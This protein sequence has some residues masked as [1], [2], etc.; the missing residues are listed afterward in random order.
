MQK[1]ETTLTL[2]VGTVF[3][4]VGKSIQIY[5]MTHNLVKDYFISF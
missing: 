1:R 3:V 2:K 5:A 4:W